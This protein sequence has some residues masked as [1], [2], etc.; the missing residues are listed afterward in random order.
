VIW[1]FPRGLII[2][3]NFSIILWIIATAPVLDTYCVTNE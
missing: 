2:A 1:T 3:S